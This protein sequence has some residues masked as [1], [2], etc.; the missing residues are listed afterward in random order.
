MKTKEEI[1][2]ETAEFYNI[3]NR[4]YEAGSCLYHT[5]ENKMCAVGRCKVFFHHTSCE[6]THT[7][8]TVLRG[9]RDTTNWLW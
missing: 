5:K 9:W 8:H 1:I 4:A 6:V 3:E 7:G 2:K